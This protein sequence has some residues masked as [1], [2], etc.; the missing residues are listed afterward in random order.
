MA[1]DNG[2]IATLYGD[3]YATTVPKVLGDQHKFLLDSIEA[4]LAGK[5]NPTLLVLGPGGFVLPYSCKYTSDGKLGTT[6]R[7]RVK[8]MLG[9]G[10]LV[11]LD[12]VVDYDKSG[13]IKEF[14]VL[15]KMGFFEPDYFHLGSFIQHGHL[16]LL[17]TKPGTISFVRNNLRNALN[18]TPGSVDAV[19]A[20]LSIHHA[21]ITRAE[22]KRVYDEI[23]HILK[24]GGMLHLGEGNVSMNYTED[25]IIRI[26]QDIA[27]INGIPTFLTDFREEGSDYCLNAVFEPGKKYSALPVVEKTMPYASTMIVSR[28]GE[29]IVQTIKD[30]ETTAKELQARGYCSARAC[31]RTTV[32]MP[33]IDPAMP[34]DVENHIKQVDRFYNA[35]EKRISDGYLRVDENL[36]EKITDG[37]ADE[38]AKAKKG[39][40]EYYMGQQQILTALKDA[41]FDRVMVKHHET[42]PFYNIVAVK[43]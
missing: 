29:V 36:V 34:E 28:D 4:G 1:D 27:G 8:K 21:S 13:L 3:A 15:T 43:P 41:G 19:D 24:P 30:A 39:I 7:D 22:L 26:G 31:G 25:K 2:G 35:I 16:C 17:H 38:R 37:V 10:R 6:N 9:N 42:E 20:N 40:V 33:L 32:K 14:D 23:Y 11:L 12:Y 18:I 5:V